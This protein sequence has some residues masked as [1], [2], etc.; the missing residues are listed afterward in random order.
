MATSMV[1]IRIEAKGGGQ[2]TRMPQGWRRIILP[3]SSVRAR[4]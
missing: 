2:T 1:I 4:A 3:T